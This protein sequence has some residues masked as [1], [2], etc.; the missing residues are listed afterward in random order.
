MN[1]LAAEV[2]AHWGT[3]SR[4]ADVDLGQRL[5]LERER[6]RSKFYELTRLAFGERAPELLE[7][8]LGMGTAADAG[9]ALAPVL[10]AALI[11]S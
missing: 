5:P 6:L 3:L 9:E 1:H 2:T 7:V 11:R 10:D 8:L 4:F